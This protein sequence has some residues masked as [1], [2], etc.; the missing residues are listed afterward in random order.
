MS[1]IKENDHRWRKKD[2]AVCM[3]RINT[4]Y[5]SRL[6]CLGSFSLSASHLFCSNTRGSTRRA[7]IQPVSSLRELIYSNYLHSSF[8]NDRTCTC[9][10]L[11]YDFRWIR[12]LQWVYQSSGQRPMEQHSVEGSTAGSYGWRKTTFIF[13]PPHPFLWSLWFDRKAGH[14]KEI[15]GVKIMRTN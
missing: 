11:L 4:P 15:G 14:N 8:I 12:H 7:K 6:I 13:L 1:K 5:L 2:S 3:H 10:A 9:F